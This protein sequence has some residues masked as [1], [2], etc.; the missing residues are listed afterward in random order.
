M[1][2]Y[3]VQNHSKTKLWRLY[4]YTNNK[5]ATEWLIEKEFEKYHRKHFGNKLSKT[6]KMSLKDVEKRLNT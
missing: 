4:D 5:W 6:M 3:P 1:I 2:F